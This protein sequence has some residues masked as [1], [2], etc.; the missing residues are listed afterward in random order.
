MNGDEL[1]LGEKVFVKER[2]G[3]AAE[4]DLLDRKIVGGDIIQPQLKI[5]KAAVNSDK[6]LFEK[7]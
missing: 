2:E 4:K 3:G 1:K 7:K 6:N 5:T